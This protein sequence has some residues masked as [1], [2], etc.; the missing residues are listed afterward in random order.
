MASDENAA[1]ALGLG[2][3]LMLAGS[4]LRDTVGKRAQ[5]EFGLTALQSDML[6]LLALRGSMISTE[7]A[8]TCG[9]N[10]STVT[11]AVDAGIE[12]GLMRRERNE[13]DRRLVDI[14]L[15]AAGKRMAE[16]VRALVADLARSAL[17]GVDQPAVLAASLA[18]VTRNLDKG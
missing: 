10:A 5:R 6:L 7:L 1:A 13:A 4:R 8:V 15:T 18:Q 16:R 12:R 17:E 11:H 3:D 14:A 9:V 2:R